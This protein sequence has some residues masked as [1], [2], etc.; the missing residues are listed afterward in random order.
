MAVAMVTATTMA[1]GGGGGDTTTAA[2]EGSLTKWPGGTPRRCLGGGCGCMMTVIVATTTAAVTVDEIAIGADGGRLGGQDR[3]EIHRSLDGTK[4]GREGVTACC[5]AA[6]RSTGSAVI[7]V[8]A[9]T[10]GKAASIGFVP[11]LRVI[12]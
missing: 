8:V 4:S 1:G 2:A 10:S 12:G 5:H 9:E 3:L 7:G 6:T 11:S